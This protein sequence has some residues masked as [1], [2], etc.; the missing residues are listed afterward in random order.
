M[1]K[2]LFFILGL[3][4]LYSIGCY[5]QEDAHL[6]RMTDDLLQLRKQ[7]VSSDAL[8]KIVVGWSVSQKPKITL[9]DEIKRDIINEFRGKGANKFKMN[10][11]VTHV[12]NRQNTGM[13][14]KGDYF[15]STEKDIYYSAIEKNIR[16]KSTATYTLTGHVGVQEFVFMSFN[17][18]TKFSARVCGMVAKPIVGKSGTLSVKLPKVTKDKKIEIAITNESGSNESF[19][20]LN[21]NPQK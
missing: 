12:Y 18:K 2:S 4:L 6:K 16:G 13:V 9:M 10:Q 14:S 20:I 5:A 19:I 21:H 3:G 15:N 7:N 11:I 8:N 1:K 17:P